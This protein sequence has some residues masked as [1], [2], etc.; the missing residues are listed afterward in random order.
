MI[1]W[2]CRTGPTS[3]YSAR[4]F[5]SPAAIIT[6][7]GPEPISAGFDRRT[8]GLTAVR[9]GTSPDRPAAG[10]HALGCRV[11]LSLARRPLRTADS[12]C[13][14]PRTNRSA[15]GHSQRVAG[16]ALTGCTGVVC[17]P[18][19]VAG[20]DLSG[21]H[22]HSGPLCAVVDESAH[23]RAAS[24]RL[25]SC[26]R[27]RT[28]RR[29]RVASVVTSGQLAAMLETRKDP[30]KENAFRRARSAAGGRNGGT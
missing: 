18:Y 17:T 9:K 10:W 30:S 4:A 27:L 22:G 23:H 29:R 3:I 15:H 7:S 11:A 19:F 13:G 12:T 14:C 26:V 21:Q 5:C 24:G 2:R 6:E 25:H 8:S 28:H 1:K 20:E 16:G